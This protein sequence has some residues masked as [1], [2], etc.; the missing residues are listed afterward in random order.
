[1]NNAASY[2]NRVPPALPFW[3]SLTLVPVAWVGAAFGGWALALLPLYAWVA[4]SLL[5][6]AIG[7]DIRNP[8]IDAPE[9][10]TL[11]HQRITL[12]WPFVQLLTT[13]PLLAYATSADHLSSVEKVVLFFG[14]GLM[15]G[16]IGVVYAH[17]L[18]HKRSRLERFLADILMGM[19]LYGHYRSEHLLVHHV[20]VGTPRDPVTA[21]YR[22]NF[23]KFYP[24]VLVQSLAS[25]FRAERAML[26]RRNRP[27]WHS[28]NPFWR[29][30][31]FAGGFLTLAFLIGGWSGL[32]LFLISAGFAIFQLELVNYIEHYGLTRKHLGDGKYERQLPRHSWNSA[33][34][35]TSALLINVTRHSD[36]HSRPDR[37]YPLLQTPD[38]EEAPHLPFG[39]AVMTTM[40]LI[41]PIWM[42]LMNP[43]IRAWRQQFYPEIEDWSAYDKGA[44]PLPSPVTPTSSSR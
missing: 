21:K 1:M 12:I 36:H 18:M 16:T 14:V 9:E 19:A 39:Y 15:S 8:D 4:F 22:E 6:A 11:W 33:H 32:A 26:A 44:N 27:V 34:A 13:F 20:H 29:Y 5:D 3:V 28:A 17:E 42:R 31:G 25:S 38:E 7:V 30:L 41:P 40:A 23:W 2:P 37:P 10:T 24:R 43:R 35:A